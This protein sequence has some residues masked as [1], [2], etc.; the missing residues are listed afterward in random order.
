MIW[1]EDMET[2]SGVLPLYEVNPL[3]TTEIPHEKSIPRSI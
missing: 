2:T 1:S 3:I